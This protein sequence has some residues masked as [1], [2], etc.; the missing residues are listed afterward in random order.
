MDVSGLEVNSFWIH[1]PEAPG[2][3]QCVHPQ[4]ENIPWTYATAHLPSDGEYF[5][6]NRVDGTLSDV[7][8]Q[9]FCNVA[10][11]VP[12]CNQP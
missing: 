10:H 7:Q 4:A 6:L 11:W 12:C 2:N 8:L 9:R 5:D 3:R 1:D